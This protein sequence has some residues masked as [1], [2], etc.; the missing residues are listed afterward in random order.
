MKAVESHSLA[1]SVALLAIVGVAF[2]AQP[3]DV[4]VCDGAGNTA[5]GQAPLVNL[6]VVPQYSSGYVVLKSNTTGSTR[7]AARVRF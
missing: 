2:G 1:L 7:L 6:M 4:V 3:P 5:M